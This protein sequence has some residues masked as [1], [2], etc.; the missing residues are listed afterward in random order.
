MD[1]SF[2]LKISLSFVVGSLWVTLTTLSAERFGSKVGG[3]IG[4]L[5]STVVIALLFIGIT[6]SPAIAAEATT[7]MPLAQGLNGLF[8][9]VFILIIRRGLSAALITSL[10]VWFINAT[11]LYLLDLQSFL[12][13]L[14]GWLIL[15]AFSYLAVERWMRISSQGKQTISYQPSQLVWRALFGGSVISLAVIMGKLGGPLL[16]GI[17]GSFPAMFLS[18]LVITA[19]TGGGDFSRS[20]GKSMLVSGLINVPIYEIMVRA[21]YPSIGLG[22]ATLISLLGSM[23]TG[24][25]TYRFITTRMT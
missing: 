19:R 2:W 16:G 8:V 5:P 4:G 9:L 13:S 21:L 20:V 24:Y 7:S 12:V 11:I 1:A 25:L 17:F 6:Q 23:A 10:L 15:L 18:T 14:A 22:W 3:L